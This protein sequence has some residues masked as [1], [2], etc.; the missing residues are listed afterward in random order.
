[1]SNVLATS[2][3]VAKTALAVLEN[4][5]T[6]SSKVNR[7]YE[8][9]FDSNMSRGYA[10]GNTIMIKRPP[11]YTYRAGSVGVPQA[12]VESTVP[13]TLTQGGVDLS[14]TSAERTLSLTQLDKKIYAAMAPVANE[15]DRQGLA[16]AETAVFNQVGTAG[17]PPATQLAATQLVAA[18]NQ[19]LDEM[20]APRDRTRA[21]IMGPALNASL[22]SG[23][24]GLFNSQG[25]LD[26]QYKSGLMVDA[27][28]LDMGM[29]QNVARHTNGAQVATGSA[30]TVG[31]TGAAFAVTGTA[32]TISRGTVVT[33]P[34][35]FSVNAQSR[36]STGVLMQFV[37]TSDLAAGA[38]SI[39]VSPTAVAT[40]VFQNVSGVST[41]G[42]FL[43]TNSAASAI[44]DVNVAFHPDAFTLACVPMWM[45]SGL[46]PRAYRETSNGFS[47]RVVE[48][49][50]AI[51][52]SSFMR[53]DV[54]F[55][56]AATY[57]EL[58]VRVL[59]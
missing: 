1:M 23:F 57:P 35:V 48:A 25:Q 33:F 58:A 30:T 10:P 5:L 20:S 31:G 21:L 42:N 41:A 2:T 52:D 32:G 46:G 14:F 22:V 18:A 29:D 44:Y 34:G 36:V 7:E 40:G 17:T 28:G 12:T 39:P 55:A 26:K 19:R 45:P 50:D 8:T 43:I 27:F 6:F 38:T 9:E 4:M 59:A 51:N 16:L 47:V 24:A 49:Y 54:L 3:I 37:V 11:R 56:W 15:I 13:L 53:I